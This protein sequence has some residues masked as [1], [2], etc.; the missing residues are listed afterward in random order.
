MLND[1]GRWEL[2]E[3][4]AIRSEPVRVMKRSGERA[5]PSSPAGSH[6]ENGSFTRGRGIH[7]RIRSVEPDADPNPLARRR[8]KFR[9]GLG[10]RR[11]DDVGIG[12]ARDQ[13]RE[14]GVHSSGW[15]ALSATA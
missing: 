14:F 2:S 10:N 5:R 11:V 6:E 13:D 4:E 8:K 7:F 9:S 1:S 15:S 12:R 3:T